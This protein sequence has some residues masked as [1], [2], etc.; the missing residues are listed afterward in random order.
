MKM[1]LCD[2]IIINDEEKMLIP[3]VL[4]IHQRLLL[5]DAEGKKND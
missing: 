2:V 3:Q 1:K 4:E 5:M